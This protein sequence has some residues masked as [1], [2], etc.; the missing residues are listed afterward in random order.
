MRIAV[1]GSG[2]S[3]LASAWLLSQ[4]HEVV[5]FEQERRAGGHTNTVVVPTPQG[6]QPVDTGF[7]VY[8][9]LNYP[10]LTAMFRELGVVTQPSDM[11]F[12]VSIGAGR[13]EYAGDNLRTLFAQ[14]A[15]LVSGRHWRML[16]DILHF[17]AQAKRLWRDGALP[18]LPIGDWLTQEGYSLAFRTRYLLPMA[19]SIWSCSMRQAGQFPVSYFV[20]FYYR[21]RLLNIVDRPRWRMVTGGSRSYVE[22]LL[23]R[24][25]GELR[26]GARVLGLRRGDDAAFVATATGEERFDA[27]V[28]AAHSDQALRLLQDADA[29]ERRILGAIGYAPNRA[30]LHRDTRLMPQRKSVW[31]AWNYIGPPDGDEAVNDREICLS[32]WM[33]RLQSIPGDAPYIVTLNPWTPPAEDTVLYQTVY[34]HPQYTAAAV[35][36]QKELPSIQGRRR[37]WFCGAWTGF[38]FHED[39]LRS[40]L[41]VAAAFGCTPAWAPATS[42]IPE[43]AGRGA[44]LVG[45]A[46]I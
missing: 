37:L 34:E 24:F 33:N 32:Y 11:S 19:G 5:L 30:F 29:G 41:V 3:G 36:A 12:A 6:D 13:V 7:I 16:A 17:N 22:K 44:A 18:D 23:G 26:F 27:V 2:I 46:A 40:A 43:T 45:E 10:N 9:E 1:I 21:H 39:G 8:N 14:G 31:A 15:N 4:R 42:A 28:S 38:G 35:A 25:R 20:D